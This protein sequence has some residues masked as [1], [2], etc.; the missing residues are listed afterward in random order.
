M[1]LGVGVILE[2]FAPTE[3]FELYIP[4]LVEYLKH[5]DARVRQDVCHYLSL[6]KKT[7]VLKYIEPLLK[8]DNA[9]VRDEATDSI[10]AL[11]DDTG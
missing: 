8:D 3:G 4:D 11:N 7:E 10:E 2:E 1:K 6:T 5:D 9:D